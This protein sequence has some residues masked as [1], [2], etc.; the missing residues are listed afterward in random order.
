MADSQTVTVISPNPYHRS[1]HV[2]GEEVSFALDAETRTSRAE[3]TPEVAKVFAGEAGYYVPAL[4]GE[5]DEQRPG[6]SRSRGLKQLV[7]IADGRASTLARAGIETL[8]ALRAAVP[9]EVAER[10][11]LNEGDI[12]DWQEQA[13]A[14]V[15]DEEDEA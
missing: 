4:D 3:V 6:G 10:T 9:A 8:G 7:G 2:A 14:L 11:G 13:R 15:R 1:A 12:I 5:Q